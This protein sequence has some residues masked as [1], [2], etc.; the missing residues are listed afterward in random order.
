MEFAVY[1]A[2]NPVF[3]AFSFYAALLAA[4]MLAMAFLTGRQRMSKRVLLCACCLLNNKL[5]NNFLL[6][7]HL[8]TLKMLH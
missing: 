1:S 3:A 7:R 2:D 8:Q 6:H 5:I 4:K